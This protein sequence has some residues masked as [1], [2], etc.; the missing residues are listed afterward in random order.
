M[1]F[2]VGFQNLSHFHRLFHK[3]H[4]ITPLQYRKAHS[5]EQALF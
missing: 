4:H 3:R 1:C 5:Q 2:A